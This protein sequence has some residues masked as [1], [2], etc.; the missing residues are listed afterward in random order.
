[1]AT[2]PGHV[3][4]PPVKLAYVAHYGSGQDINSKTFHESLFLNAHFE[5]T[6]ILNKYNIRMDINVTF[7]IVSV[8]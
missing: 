4:T 1:M 6:N 3:W 2:S 7:L 5:D 8:R